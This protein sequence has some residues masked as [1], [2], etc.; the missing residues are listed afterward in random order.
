MQLQK[1]VCTAE[2]QPAPIPKSVHWPKNLLLQKTVYP[3]I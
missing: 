1:D 2:M 3:Q